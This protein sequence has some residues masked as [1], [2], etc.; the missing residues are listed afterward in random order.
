MSNFLIFCSTILFFVAN[1]IHGHQDHLPIMYLWYQISLAWQSHRNGIQ[2]KL[3]ASL[4][5][6]VRFANLKTYSLGLQVHTQAEHV[7]NT[8]W[9][10]VSAHEHQWVSG[11]MH[12]NAIEGVWTPIECAWLPLSHYWM[13]ITVVWPWQRS[14]LCQIWTCPECLW[15]CLNSCVWVLNTSWTLVSAHEHQ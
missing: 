3:R 14:H 11:N 7:L 4:Q 2:R 5:A 8:S 10:L 9:T 6:V 15:V 13:Q 1:L 12:M